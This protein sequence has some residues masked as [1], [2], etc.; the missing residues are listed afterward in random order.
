MGRPT[1]LTK[2]LQ[3]RIC[4]ELEK[5]HFRRFAAGLV[6][7][8]EATL[9]RWYHRGAS[10]PKGIY[11][12]FHDAVNLAEA[13]WVDTANDMLRASAAQNPKSIQFALSRRHADLY[14]RRDNVEHH[15]P[16]DKA[17]EQGALREMLL[18]RLGKFLPDPSEPAA[19]APAPIPAPSAPLTPAEDPPAPAPE[20]PDSARREQRDVCAACDGPWDESHVCEGS[21][22]A[23]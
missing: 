7:I 16:E 21:T 4:A 9:Q 15:S 11:A 8:D 1:K 5:G 22:H 2:E 10:E 20:T 18:E 23:R 19:P 17:A 12:D 13:K 3:A 14:G 6:G